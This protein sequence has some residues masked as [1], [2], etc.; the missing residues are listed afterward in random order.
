MRLAAANLLDDHHGAPVLW[1]ILVLI[2]ILLLLWLWPW[3]W[4]FEGLCLLLSWLL[5][6]LLSAL[7]RRLR[8]ARPVGARRAQQRLE[9]RIRQRR[10]IRPWIAL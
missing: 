3:L 7:R 5:A 8:A 1:P 6:L 4:D 2:L 10:C 9:V